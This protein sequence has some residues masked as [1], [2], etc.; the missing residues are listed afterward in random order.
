MKN[1]IALILLL[2][3]MPLFGNSQELT[4]ATEAGED[5]DLYGVLGL[6][7]EAEDLE[8]FEKKINSEDNDINNLDLNKDEEVDMVKVI[9]HKG[10]STH[11]LIL[12]AVL[13][14][15]D[16]Q[17]IATIEIEQHAEDQISLQVIGDPDIYGPN[18]ILEPAP[19]ESNIRIYSPMAVFVSVHLWRPVR[20]LFRPGR[21][22][23]V[24]PI[25]W[26]PRPPWFRPWRPIPRSSWRA[27]ANRWHSPRY[28]SARTRHSP[29]GRNMYTTQRRTSPTA[30][31]NFGPAPTPYKSPAASPAKQQQKHSTTAPAKRQSPARQTSPKK[32]KGPPN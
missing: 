6:F 25:V 27:R 20:V 23:F 9:E 5:F 26:R 14:E 30:K 17:D 4:P 8:D 1:I 18:Y 13:G 10:G 16:A 7:E 24:S 22:V 29:R 19:E 28:R 21:A 32:K 2:F 15:N 31:K 12:Q 3:L 11:L